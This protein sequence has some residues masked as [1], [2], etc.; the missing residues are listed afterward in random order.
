MMDPWMKTV[1]LSAQDSDG[2]EGHT[3]AHERLGRCSWSRRDFCDSLDRRK[4]D[5]KLR[6]LLA[7]DISGLQTIQSR[8]V[9][10]K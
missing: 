9:L 1:I 7:G 4:L 10:L 6:W 3:L 2:E 8:F 5:D